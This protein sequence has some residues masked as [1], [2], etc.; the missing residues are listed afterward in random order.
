MEVCLVVPQLR[1]FS[2]IDHPFNICISIL[3]VRRENYSTNKKGEG[4]IIV[5][6][7][8]KQSTFG[9]GAKG[10]LGAMK[11]SS[12]L[13]KKLSKKRSSNGASGN[14]TSFNLRP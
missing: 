5:E 1:V 9:D 12:R 14:A 10:M 7:V 8:D 3:T 4:I 11:V 6:N 2:Q 13:K